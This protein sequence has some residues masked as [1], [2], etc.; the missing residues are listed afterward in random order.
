M[1][2]FF[3]KNTCRALHHHRA[4]VAPF[5]FFFFFFFFGK[6]NLIKALTTEKKFLPETDRKIDVSSTFD[7]ILWLKLQQ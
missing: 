1:V 6:K 4:M 3:V 7:K 5:F 2:V